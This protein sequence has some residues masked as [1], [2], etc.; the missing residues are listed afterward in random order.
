MHQIGSG[1]NGLGIGSFGLDWSTI[2]G[3]LGSPLA[4]PATAIF[5]IMISY[6]LIVYVLLPLG[7][8]T[9]S[10]NAKR[11]PLISANVFDSHG[12]PY[13]ITRIINDNNFTLNGYQEEIYSK[14]NIT[15]SFALVYGTT[16]ASVTAAIM[17][18]ALH[19]GKYVL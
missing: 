5:N 7:Y 18:V 1:L 19:H 3:F 17:H 4:T 13:N 6:I 11:F 14:L 16:F 8:W 10:Y 15:F 2:A 9:N 12:Q